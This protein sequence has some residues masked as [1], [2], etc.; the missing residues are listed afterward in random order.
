MEILLPILVI[1]VVSVFFYL[2]YKQFMNIH[3]Y[4]NDIK[5]TLQT[6]VIKIDTKLTNTISRINQTHADS[7]KKIIVMQTLNH[8]KNIAPE[9][10]DSDSLEDDR[11]DRQLYMGS[12]DESVKGVRHKECNHILS[13]DNAQTDDKDLP[14]YVSLKQENKP[15]S[16]IPIE[17][18]LTNISIE[19][20]TTDAPVATLQN[21]VD[22]EKIKD[23]L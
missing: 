22:A 9:Q 8:Q 5:E 19:N 12:D 1:I 14:I 4:F 13:D 21:Q 16:S 3:N 6:E 10:Q 20:K 18:K 11:K 17:S 15:N 23:A 7:L 2:I